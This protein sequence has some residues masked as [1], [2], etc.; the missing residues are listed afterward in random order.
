MYS[1]VVYYF[2]C[3]LLE[4]WAHK[5]SIEKPINANK[6][7]LLKLARGTLVL[8]SRHYSFLSLFTLWKRSG[9]LLLK[10]DFLDKRIW[11]L[12]RI[13]LCMA[14]KEINITLVT[15]RHRT[16]TYDIWPLFWGKN[17]QRQYFQN[18]VHIK[19]SQ[20][21]DHTHLSNV[22]WIWG[23]QWSNWIMAIE[24]NGTGPL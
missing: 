7:S 23:G 17:N 13:E 21:V 24:N 10:R 20:L 2:H 6:I 11:S 22:Y 12:Q 19:C 15:Q 9:W 4:L 5:N 1:T 3:L 8:C 14:Y 18:H 16:N